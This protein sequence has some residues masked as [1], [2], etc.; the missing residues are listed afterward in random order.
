M[1]IS[2]ENLYFELDQDRFLV[3]SQ[4][5]WAGVSCELSDGRLITGMSLIPT[6]A[7]EIDID[8]DGAHV[9]ERDDKAPFGP[10]LDSELRE[11]V[12]RLIAEFLDAFSS[13]AIKVWRQ[14]RRPSPVEQGA[15]FDTPATEFT[16]YRN[17]DG[18]FRTE[19][20][21][22]VTFASLTYVGN[23]IHLTPSGQRV[24]I[25]F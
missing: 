3:I 23:G 16:L 1:P 25:F 2:L 15:L 8:F 18:S 19:D 9:R 5:S 14:K 4:Q 22:L 24:R 11:S 20:G 21:L 12:K 10:H 17:S 6:E 7:D 13:N